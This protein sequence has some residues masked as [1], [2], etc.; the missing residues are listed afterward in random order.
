[1][2]RSGRHRNQRAWRAVSTLAHP[3]SVR[4]RPARVRPAA[5]RSWRGGPGIYRPAAG[6][7][8]VA[9]GPGQSG[10][11]RSG[12]RRWPPARCPRCGR[13]GALYRAYEPFQR[14][15][16]TLHAGRVWCPGVA[17]VLLDGGAVVVDPGLVGQ[18]QHQR[19]GTGVGTGAGGES[20]VIEDGHL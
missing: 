20:V 2:R 10:R 13:G 4:P 18:S 9:H 11:R 1:M 6:C 5:R 14:Q 17:S 8:P 7:P 19:P 16:G 12:P 15:Q 3:W